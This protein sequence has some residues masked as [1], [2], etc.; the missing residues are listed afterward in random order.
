MLSLW[1]LTPLCVR[2]NNLNQFSKHTPRGSYGRLHQCIYA[3]D[4]CQQRSIS[5]Q[6]IDGWVGRSPQPPAEKWRELAQVLLPSLCRQLSITDDS[7]RCRRCLFS[8]F[9]QAAKTNIFLM[10]VC[11]V[12]TSWRMCQLHVNVIAILRTLNDV[13]LVYKMSILS[14]GGGDK[15]KKQTFHW[16]S[17]IFPRVFNHQHAARRVLVN[18]CLFLENMP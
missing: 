7:S 18:R 14:G 6:V 5:L 9:S 13:R 15:T 16:R 3:N 12:C 8:R 1:A 17:Y 10:T 2:F 11:T 4:K